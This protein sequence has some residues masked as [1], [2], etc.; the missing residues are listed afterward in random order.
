M[1]DRETVNT[2]HQADVSAQL[3]K[4][5]SEVSSPSLATTLARLAM[6]RNSQTHAS[7]FPNTFL[8]SFRGSRLWLSMTFLP[9]TETTTQVRYDLFTSSLKAEPGE[10]D[11]SSAIEAVIQTR[12]TQLETEYQSIR[13]EEV[14]NPEGTSRILAH[15]HD[16]TKLERAHGAQ[17]RPAMRQPKGSSLFQQAEQRK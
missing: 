2:Q 5:V 14:Q 15:L 3:E 9:A 10:N 6:Q 12:I 7:V 8:Y 4:R 11:L 1:A 13:A 17:V 16:H